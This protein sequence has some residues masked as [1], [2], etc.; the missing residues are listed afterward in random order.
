ME[1]QA[2]LADEQAEGAAAVGESVSAFKS[3]VE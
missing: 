3:A 2:V 1:V